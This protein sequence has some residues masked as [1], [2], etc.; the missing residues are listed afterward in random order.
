MC[1]SVRQTNRGARVAVSVL[2][3]EVPQVDG[4]LVEFVIAQIS[5]S[6]QSTE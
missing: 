5:M 1:V 6:Q 2:V 3:A 4:Q